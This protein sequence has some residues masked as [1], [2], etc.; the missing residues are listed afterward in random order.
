MREFKLP[1]V[2]TRHYLLLVGYSIFLALT[3][4]LL[5]GGY[6][7]FLL[8]YLNGTGLVAV[9]FFIRWFSLPLVLF[10]VAS[11]TY[12]KGNV[13]NGLLYALPFA[14]L[15]VA[16]L[17]FAIIGYSGNAT[18]LPVVVIGFS[19]GVGCALL[20]IL[21]QQLLATQAVFSA[22]FIVIV[23]AVISPILHFLLG[24][25]PDSYALLV[26]FLLLVPLCA[27]LFFQSKSGLSFSDQR[28]S[29]VPC[30]DRS[31]GQAVAKILFQPLLGISLSAFVIGLMQVMVMFGGDA[32]LINSI[33]MFGMLG[34]GLI[35]S[36][37]WIAIYPRFSPEAIYRVVF[38]LTATAYLL[39]P[40]L[41]SGFFYAFVTISFLIFAIVSALMVITCLQVSRDH[42]LQPML[43]YGCFAGIVYLAA[44]LGS[45][46]GYIFLGSDNFGLTQLLT[47]AL[48]AV[49]ILSFVLLLARRKQQD[50]ASRVVGFPVHGSGLVSEATIIRCQQIQELYSLSDRETEIAVLLACG[51]DVPAIAK[52]L[53]IS[54]NTVRTHMKNFYKKLDVHNKQDFLN[55]LDEEVKC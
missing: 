7:P 40:F 37:V 26:S 15:A 27:F 8:P 35:L 5:W 29:T 23:S 49:Y 1:L 6:V 18:L 12:H 55:L 42:G 13:A 2:T 51:R 30:Q 3:A 33:K 10:I 39:L 17:A 9:D 45:V 16:A 52:K 36:V 44:A 4:T 38:P 25:I 53:F 54:E 48:I 34:S 47:I 11:V 24:L 41:G 31:G 14:F 46:V 28:F 50:R 22:G 19:C 43:I 32:R 20:F 21:F